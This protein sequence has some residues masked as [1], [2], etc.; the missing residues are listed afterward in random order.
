MHF[1]TLALLLLI[2]SLG[3]SAIGQ[4]KT[5]PRKA[6]TSNS[7]NTWRLVSLNVKGSQRYTPEEILASC[8]LQVGQPANEEDFKKATDLLGQTGLFS[9]A[10]YSYTYSSEGVKLELQLADNNQLVPA[11]FD[12]FVWLTDKELLDQLKGRVPLFKGLLPTDGDMADEV[13]NALQAVLIEHKVQGKADYIRQGA[14]NEDR[15]S[16]V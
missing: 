8:G 3:T 10:S 14:D 13:S 9:N 15:K 12:N 16:V 11:H 6:P 7:N 5:A 2:A 1:R 4:K